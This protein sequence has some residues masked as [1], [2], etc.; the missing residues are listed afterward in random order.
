MYKL[1]N[2]QTG[3][4]AIIRLEDNAIIPINKDNTDYQAY[5][6]WCAQGNVAIPADE[7]VA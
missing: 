5:L 7:G 3:Q 2:F 4:Q 1:Y 6:A